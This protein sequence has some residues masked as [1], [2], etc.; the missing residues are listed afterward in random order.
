MSKISHPRHTAQTVVQVHP[1]HPAWGYV[2]SFT[3]TAD[4]RV[5]MITDTDQNWIS[6]TDAKV[7]FEQNAAQGWR[8]HQI[9]L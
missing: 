5:L 8:I 7:E 4:G 9:G 2:V 1:N 3:P 6:E